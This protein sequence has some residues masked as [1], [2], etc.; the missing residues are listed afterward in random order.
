M[1]VIIQIRQLTIRMITTQIS[2]GVVVIHFI[3]NKTKL[4][5]SSEL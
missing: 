3:L 1:I 5:G 2:S 4:D